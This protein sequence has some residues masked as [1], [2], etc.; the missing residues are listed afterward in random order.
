M[1]KKTIRVINYS[2]MAFV[3]SNYECFWD[4]VWIK[5]HVGKGKVVSEGPCIISRTDL[6]NGI[7]T[8]KE[9]RSKYVDYN[10]NWFLNELERIEDGFDDG[11]MFDV[12][13]RPEWPNGIPD[14]FVN[15]EHISREVV[16]EA[17]EWYLRR[18][19]VLKSE[20]RFV[21]SKP[22]IFLFSMGVAS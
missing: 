21:W 3:G 22:N 17:I 4:D 6:L 5:Y 18:K 12:L 15:S 13:I 8:G 14:I 7:K 9:L 11:N 19:G 10:D 20:P 2:P 1:S 16:E